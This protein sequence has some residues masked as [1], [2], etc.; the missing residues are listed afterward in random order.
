MKSVKAP[1]GKSGTIRRTYCTEI[2]PIKTFVESGNAIDFK[3][4]EALHNFVLNIDNQLFCSNVQTEVEHMYDELRRLFEA[5]QRNI[6]KL[7][8]NF[9]C[10]KKNHAFTEND[11]A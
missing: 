11:S 5:F 6:N 3:G 10:K 8:L 2:Q 4:F 9:N 7:T 1:F